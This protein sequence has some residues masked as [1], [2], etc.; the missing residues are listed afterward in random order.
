MEFLLQLDMQSPQSV[1]VEPAFPAFMFSTVK[2]LYLH[3][4]VHFMQNRQFESILILKGDI[5]PKKLPISPIG[6]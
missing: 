1:H 5:F 4:S 6:Q 3:F 2:A